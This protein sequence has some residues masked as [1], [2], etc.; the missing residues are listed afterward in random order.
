MFVAPSLGKIVVRSPSG[1]QMHLEVREVS[2]THACTLGHQEVVYSRLDEPLCS[3]GLPQDMADT[4]LPS[5]RR[6]GP[7]SL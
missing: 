2:S 4:G 7:Q 6:N 3:L 1:T 5:R